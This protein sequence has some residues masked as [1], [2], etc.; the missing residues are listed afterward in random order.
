[1]P[2]PKSLCYS[3]VENFALR[4]LDH[5]LPT[6]FWGCRS[7]HLRRGVLSDKRKMTTVVI[8]NTFDLGQHMPFTHKNL[9]ISANIFSQMFI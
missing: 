2:K 9:S 8:S 7:R 5:P 4:I 6:S 3:I 1:M